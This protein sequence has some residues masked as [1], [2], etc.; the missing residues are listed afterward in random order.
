M[1]QW[2]IKVANLLS[3]KYG[4]YPKLSGYTQWNHKDLKRGGRRGKP[5]GDMTVEAGS[6]SCNVPG[7]EIEEGATSQGMLAEPRS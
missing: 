1:W 2:G 7:P 4:D 3:L 6:K 5:E